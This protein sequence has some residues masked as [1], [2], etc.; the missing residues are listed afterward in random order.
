VKAWVLENYEKWDTS[1]PAWFNDT[2]I[3][4][5]P[6]D[7]IPIPNLEALLEAGG[8]ER[9]RKNSILMQRASLSLPSVDKE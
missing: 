7:M 1:K 8:G 3:A 2:N 5:I 4:C 6:S 9:P